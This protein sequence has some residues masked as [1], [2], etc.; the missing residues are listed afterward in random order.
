MARGRTRPLSRRRFLKRSAAA[1]A[2]VL[3]L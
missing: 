3:F 1:G 2:G